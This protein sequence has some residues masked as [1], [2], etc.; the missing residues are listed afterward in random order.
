MLLHQTVRPGDLG[1]PAVEDFL[2]GACPLTIGVDFILRQRA[3]TVVPLHAAG[4]VGLPRG[5][6]AT[7]EILAE[8]QATPDRLQAAIYR[9]R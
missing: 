4:P 3:E 1:H 5:L 2:G 7:M 9:R 8:A 6:V